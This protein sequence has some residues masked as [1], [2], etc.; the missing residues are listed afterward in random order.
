MSRKFI[1]RALEIEA[2]RFGFDDQP[3]WCLYSEQ[4]RHF[5][6]TDCDWL[7]IDTLEGTMIANDGDYVIQGI[8]GEI[9]PCRDDIFLISYDEVLDDYAKTISGLSTV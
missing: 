8:K 4:V 2:F 9:Y 1:K 6:N 5:S 3:E 7:E